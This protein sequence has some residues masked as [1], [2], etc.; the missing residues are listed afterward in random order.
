[1]VTL[2]RDLIAGAIVLGVLVLLHEWGHFIVAKWCGVRVE[3][4]SVGFG[5]RIWGKK[6]GNTDYRLS[7]LP[8]GGYV[9]MAGD[10]PVEERS[11]AP[12][13]FLSRPRWQRFLVVIAGPIVN[14]VL[15]FLILWGVYAGFGVPFD[16]YLDQ[17]PTVAAVPQGATTAV[18]PGDRILKVGGTA[19]PTW[20]TVLSVLAKAGP[21]SSVSLDIERGGAQQTLTAKIPS[22]Q[23]T[24]DGVTGYPEIPCVIERV[25]PGYP[26]KN[27]G[28]QPGDQI[29]SLNGQ[30]IV[31]WPQMVDG[32]QRSAGA[33]VHF[34]V[35]RDGKEV[36]LEI[37]PKQSLDPD[38]GQMTWVIGA[39][40]PTKNVYHTEG[41]SAAIK[42]AAA[43]TVSF[44]QSDKDVIVWLFRGKLSIVHDLAGPVGIVQFSGQAA[45]QGPAIFLVW[46]AFISLDLGLLNLL[47][48]PLLDGGHVLMF[49]IEGTLRRDLSIA[50]KE[51]FV[52]VGIVF[53][54]ALFAIV[55]YGDILRAFQSR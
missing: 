47:P 30:A 24:A 43:K 46:M 38:N 36:P 49:A 42:D 13:E 19:T 27:A 50:F 4:F 28:M 34:V 45:Q 5:P 16:A 52:Q 21:N 32:I 7:A 8:L 35:R 31:T 2:L 15:A 20:G 9:R 14:I 51:R 55:M 37:T 11:G 44:A 40:R 17:A 22:G 29:L 6:K 3:V 18:Q 23:S 33:P 41:F 12:D 10:N 39:S 25:E 53:I 26:A 54:L 1:M 48:I